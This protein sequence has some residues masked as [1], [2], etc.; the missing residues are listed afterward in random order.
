MGHDI[1]RRS[2]RIAINPYSDQ[3]LLG[4]TFTTELDIKFR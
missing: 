4:L 2:T 1:Q 3:P